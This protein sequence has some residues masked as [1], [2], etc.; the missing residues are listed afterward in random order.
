[1]VVGRQ[2]SDMAREVGDR[3]FLGAAAASGSVAVGSSL[4]R[5]EEKGM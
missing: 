5:S 2:C 4:M 1:M 3:V